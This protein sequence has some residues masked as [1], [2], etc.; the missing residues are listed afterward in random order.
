MTNNPTPSPVESKKKTIELLLEL[1]NEYSEYG[2]YPGSL[3]GFM[4]WLKQYEK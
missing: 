2:E 4:N 1:W 3:E